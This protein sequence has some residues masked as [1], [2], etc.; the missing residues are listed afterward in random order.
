M[1]KKERWIMLGAMALGVAVLPL[2]AEAFDLSG[3][4]PGKEPDGV[5]VIDGEFTVA[6]VDGEKVV[7]M[8]TAPVEECMMLFG[9]TLR[10]P[11]TVRVKIKAEKKGRSYPSFGVG[12]YGV[13][14]YRL[15]VVPARRGI[16]ILKGDEVMAKGEFAWSGS[17]WT[18]LV[19]SATSGGDGRWT[20][21]GRAWGE[22][23]AEPEDAQVKI[24]V[25]AAR[26]MGKAGILGT[27]YSG[28][29]TLFD[30]LEVTVA[31]P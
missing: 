12:L 27:P 10:G 11:A 18:S 14:G 24:D 6:E 28:M 21:E 29:P 30:E 16:E 8:G 19:L 26:V 23:E 4:D 2:G 1:K 17:G 31:E 5:F 13:S 3:M 9:D 7:K 15:R 25:D 22:G 20:I